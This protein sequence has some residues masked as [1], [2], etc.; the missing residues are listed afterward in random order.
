MP[1]FADE[2]DIIWRER[3]MERL[4]QQAALSATLGASRNVS[5]LLRDFPWLTP[6]A[7]AA[8]AST[9]QVGEQAADIAQ[10]SL[11]RQLQVTP[12]KFQ[13]TRRKQKRK[14]QEDDGGDGGL[15]GFGVGPKIGPD[16]VPGSP[17]SSL[18]RG[19]EKTV[20][21]ARREVEDKLM[22]VG[23]KPL[24]RAAGVTFNTAYQGVVGLSRMTADLF[25]E[26]TILDKPW[27]D[28]ESPSW[29]QS[30]N[31]LENL[32][33][34]GK[35]VAAQTEGGQIARSLL[36]GEDVELGTGWFADPQSPQAQR[37]AAAARAYSPQLYAG[38]AW[39]PGRGLAGFVSEPD[40][41]PFT[42]L[43]GLTDM[44]V[45]LS[46]ADPAGAVLGVLGE[47]NRVRQTFQVVPGAEDL[48]RNI[49]EAAEAGDIGKVA[50]LMD[51]A[52]PMAKKRLAWNADGSTYLADAGAGIAERPF[53]RAK[54]PI[55]W[56][57]G[58]DGSR[59]VEAL[60][61]EPSTYGKWVALNRKVPIELVHQMTDD[62]AQ[63]RALLAGE[64]G[65]SLERI[66]KYRVGIAYN[67]WLE[68]I[69]D[70][71]IDLNNVDASVRNF[72][73]AL[74]NA[75]VPAEQI[76]TVLD[77]FVDAYGR[78]DRYGAVESVFDSI[79]YQLLANGAPQEVA[80]E[81]GRM[82]R[83][84][85]AAANKYWVSSVTGN[86][87][88]M[89]LKVGDDF[90]PVHGPML[91]TERLASDL[92]LPDPRTV[93]RMVSSLRPVYE[94]R[95]YMA[96]IGVTDWA[97]SVW[98]PAVL[99]RPAWTMRVL[100]EEQVR[101]AVSGTG[102]LRHP[103]S[104][105][106]AILGDSSTD[107]R[108]AKWLSNLGQD[109][110]RDEMIRA[111]ERAGLEPPAELLKQ[112]SL[113][114]KAARKVTRAGTFDLSPGGTA[115][116]REA[117]DEGLG[118][119]ITQ[120]FSGITDS[121][122]FLRDFD[123]VYR[124][125]KV[126]AEGFV[127]ELRRLG[128]DAD[129][130]RSIRWS[131]DRFKAWGRTDV[132]M[133]W[134][135]NMAAGRD[136]AY[137]F[138]DTHDETWDSYVDL[139]YKRRD[140]FT[141]GD[142]ELLGVLQSGKV[143]KV[144]LTDE[145]YNPSEGVLGWANAVRES[146]RGPDYLKVQRY[147]VHRVGQ[148][149]EDLDVMR[150][151]VAAMFDWLMT[152][153]SN[154]LNRSPDFRI[155]AWDE[156]QRLAPLL[157]RAGRDR[158]LR[159]LKNANLPSAYK[160]NI[161]AAIVNAPREGDLSMDAF[162]MIVKR[163]ALEHV[164]GLLYHLHKKNQFADVMR[165]VFPFGEAFKE[166]VTTWARLLREYPQVP[167]RAQQ[168][169]QGARDAQ[170]DEETGLPTGHD[171]VGFFRYDPLTRQQV[172]TYP[173]SE[174]VTEKLTGVP[175]PL[176]GPLKNLNIVGNGLPGVGPAVSIP[177]AWFLPD[178][179]EYDDLRKLVFP[180]GKPEDP[181]S[182]DPFLPAWARKVRAVLNGPQSDRLYANV[183]IDVA[184][185]LLSTGEYDIQGPNAWDEV[186]RL[187]RDSKKK[188]QWLYLLRAG[189]QASTPSSPIFDFRVEDP[190]GNLVTAQVL[191]DKYNEKRKELGDPNL[192]MEWFLNKFGVDNVLTIQAKSTTTG[193]ENTV[194]LSST[195]EQRQWAVR[196]KRQ[197]AKFS[198][199][200]A[201]FAPEGGEFDPSAYQAEIDSGQ[202]TAISPEQAVRRANDRLATLIVRAATEAAGP[203]PTKA[204]SRALR[205]LRAQMREEFPGYGP[206]YSTRDTQSLIAELEQ[207]LKDK[208]LAATDAGRG[209]A[210]Y[211]AVRKEVAT[212]VENAGYAWPPTAEA[213]EPYRLILDRTAQRIIASYP[214][215][216]RMWEQVLS[217]EV[218]DA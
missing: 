42:I 170:F 67:R 179:P 115:W 1:V 127:G 118:D 108:L 107:S 165:L 17:F 36:R 206:D 158:L 95:P 51:E 15:L 73:L 57:Y 110:G 61:N 131:P 116:T 102:L 164:Q 214:Q 56:L 83:N 81:I 96:T 39:T 137:R 197:V 119:A 85:G 148:R 130:Q 97:M 136:D 151:G 174:L 178:K 120:A 24:V 126:W 213:T 58:K 161:R 11:E 92:V 40:T 98:K 70:L 13:R 201:L 10:L 33:N 54:N 60:A 124:T 88:D 155:K 173:F 91:D 181:A 6:G 23:A 93:R 160:Q 125:D 141:G 3:Q 71:R 150:R 117:G 209:L 196:H 205:N 46:P 193:F 204:Q 195:K 66:P 198:K 16:L 207:A 216:G 138:M 191:N 20:G 156:T 2:L 189:A 94:T 112:R 183:T 34:L 28:Y 79:R 146:G 22:P 157:N 184:R 99:L 154:T 162:E 200:W 152:K 63:V 18:E 25:P 8:L 59:V 49:D 199:V 68:D 62:P 37:A 218:Q 143:G 86:N 84:Q 89:L 194:G 163:R 176:K 80:D 44:A 35:G 134:R 149:E 167:R 41:T 159:T 166:I 52:V 45:A 139:V 31:P 50:S 129:I 55:Q 21:K 29:T 48:V 202:R 190:S 113:L 140:D 30:D 109:V 5:L 7:V 43:S 135:K 65:T 26:G 72:E 172:F 104:Y 186:D 145:A 203:N 77:G 53:I 75:K 9:G 100:G 74:K 4:A 192:A 128:S 38:H 215:F 82:F 101:L 114:E 105:I 64:L 87:A 142:R 78:G 47:A 123:S 182:I 187:L 122:T 208:T 106:A 153:P 121:K 168:M 90:V 211:L 217:W 132:G 69:G 177:A 169:W 14:K 175:V 32:K 147:L 144:P 185:Y 210:L 19:H 188:G 27:E 171:G 111:F 212:A 76:R 180:F 103:F 133:K 12:T